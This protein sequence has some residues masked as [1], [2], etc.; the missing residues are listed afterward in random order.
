MF[1]SFLHTRVVFKLQ[2]HT[3]ICKRREAH[4]VYLNMS[5]VAAFF[6]HICTPFNNYSEIV[7]DIGHT[8]SLIYSAFCVSCPANCTT[9]TSQCS[10]PLHVH[11]W[12]QAENCIS[13]NENYE[14]FYWCI[15]VHN[16]IA[17]RMVACHSSIWT[18]LGTGAYTRAIFIDSG[19]LQQLPCCCY[20]C[21]LF[22]LLL[23][24]SVSWNKRMQLRFVEFDVYLNYGMAVS[25]HRSTNSK[26]R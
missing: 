7:C 15:F 24:F 13:V 16:L 18:I 8:F 3:C 4:F 20:C 14:I 1:C 22:L 6:E 25:E 9:F 5:F 2:F 12:F 11:I 10:A 17:C 21:G 23:A 19:S 26:Y